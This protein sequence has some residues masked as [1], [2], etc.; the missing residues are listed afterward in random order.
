MRM[1]LGGYRVSGIGYRGIDPNPIP[2]TT[3]PNSK[4]ATPQL[5]I[6]ASVQML[7][8]VGKSLLYQRCW[9][10]PT[11]I[12]TR[13]VGEYCVDGGGPLVVVGAAVEEGVFGIIEA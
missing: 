7:P 10:V 8:S 9:A 11:C 5:T 6:G 2:D 12:K 3:Y 4:K 1:E 13:S